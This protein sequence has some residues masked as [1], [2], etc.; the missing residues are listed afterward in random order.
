MNKFFL[1]K[2]KKIVSNIQQSDLNPI[3]HYKSNVKQPN[4]QLQF[5]QLNVQSM[6]KHECCVCPTHEHTYE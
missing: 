3:N 6:N 1:D 4:H 2:T 5:K